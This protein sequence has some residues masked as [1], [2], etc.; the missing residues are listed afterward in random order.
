MEEL[1]GADVVV[2]GSGAAGLTAALAASDA[3]ARV[4]VLE[5]SEQIGG[6]TA[7]SGGALWIPLNHH[8]A[9]VGIEDSREDA[10]AYTLALTAGRVPRSLV[11]SGHEVVRRLEADSPLAFTPWNIPDY[12]Q[13]RRWCMN[14]R[15]HR[16]PAL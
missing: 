4:V 7:V 2:V 14:M 13:E 9:E 12:R 1:A 6:T 3:G 16:L 11:D 5:H 15:W 8:M 10:L